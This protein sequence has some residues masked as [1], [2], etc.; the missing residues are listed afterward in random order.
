MCHHYR[1]HLGLVCC[2]PSKIVVETG[3]IIYCILFSGQFC[4]QTVQA[5]QHVLLLSEFRHA[6]YFC[7]LCSVLLCHWTDEHNHWL[8]LS[9]LFEIYKV[10]HVRS[11]VLVIYDIASNIF[12]ILVEAMEVCPENQLVY[13]GCNIWYIYWSWR[14][15]FG[16]FCGFNAHPSLHSAGLIKWGQRFNW[17]LDL[18]NFI[19]FNLTF[20]LFV[21]FIFKIVS[22]MQK[23]KLHI[24]LFIVLDKLS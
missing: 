22:I 15:V 16:Q 9:G 3:S 23:I 18:I 7:D 6:S 8:M 21:I 24:I 13:F 1:Q 11:H 20:I 14:L 10:T 17:I 4:K 19:L 5:N 2:P 12:I